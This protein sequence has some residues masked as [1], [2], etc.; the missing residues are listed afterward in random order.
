MRLSILVLCVAVQ[1]CAPSPRGD[2]YVPLVDM[3]GKSQQAFVQD[4]QECQAYASTRMSGGQAA[5]GGAVAGGVLGALLAPKG[6]RT[7]VAA[8]G[9]VAGGTG[10]GAKAVYTQESITKQCLA[11]RGYNVLN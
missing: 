3:K 10:A 9:M 6:H 8:F 7:D 5:V 2:R 1:A 4:T 11:G